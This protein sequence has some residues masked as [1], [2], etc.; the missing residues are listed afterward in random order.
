MDLWSVFIWESP[1]IQNLNPN[2]LRTIH[3]VIILKWTSLIVGNSLFKVRH[4]EDIVYY[5]KIL[6]WSLISLFK[7]NQLKEIPHIIDKLIKMLLYARNRKCPSKW[8]T[9]QKVNM[10]SPIREALQSVRVWAWAFENNFRNFV[11]NLHLILCNFLSS[12]H[13]HGL[14]LF[15]AWCP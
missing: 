15:S 11:R 12:V 7:I 8:L 3:S 9:H 13:Q 1:S 2:N 5:A 14:T 10:S 6:Y 4:P